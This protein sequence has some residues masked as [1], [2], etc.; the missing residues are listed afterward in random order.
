MKDTDVLELV[1][2]DE[3]TLLSKALI[4]QNALDTI[5]LLSDLYYLP[6]KAFEDETISNEE[7]GMAIDLFRDECKIC[8]EQKEADSNFRKIW[9]ESMVNSAHFVTGK[10]SPEEILLLKDLTA[11]EGELVFNNF[12][13]QM[14]IGYR[15]AFYRF[16]TY[17]LISP[18]L[19]PNQAKFTLQK[20]LM[21]QVLR[22]YKYPGTLYDFLNI[23]GDQ[24]KLSEFCMHSNFSKK[25][26]IGA[27]FF[28][29]V[30]NSK[31]KRFNKLTGKRLRFTKRKDF[32]SG[33][34]NIALRKALDGILRQKPKKQIDNYIKS[35]E[36]KFMLRVL[37]VKLWVLGLYQGKLDHDFG[38]LSLTALKEFLE[39][40]FE[41]NKQN[42]DELKNILYIIK[43]DQCILNFQYLLEKYIIPIEDQE[44]EHKAYEEYYQI[45][46]GKHLE[47]ESTKI[48]KEAK[49]L[50]ENFKSSLID[51]SKKLI[52]TKKPARIY[53]G[54]RGFNKFVSKITK[55][56]KNIASKLLRLIK[57]LIKLLA[58][59]IKQIF[60]EIKEAILTFRQGMSFLF[61]R[62]KIIS[63]HQII[64]D[65]DFDF[66]GHSLLLSN[67]SEDFFQDHLKELRIRSN[68]LYPSIRFATEVIKWGLRFAT[69][70][71]W[72]KI[73]LKMAQILR[74]H[75]I[76]SAKDELVKLNFKI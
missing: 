65:Y 24:F 60:E 36:N 11:L 37:Q 70:L 76:R 55:W 52:A 69:G 13:S 49:I 26:F 50:D 25:G 14:G 48:R 59:T 1:P 34:Q 8:L 42:Q 3:R 5:Q 16:R 35:Q 44:I 43:N 51:H 10:L 19:K 20:D 46:E 6:R 58:K 38:P 45:L 41:Q 40:L 15:I 2:K 75:M 64:T 17:S 66:D 18:Q 57:S 68:A 39:M 23:L 21:E 71:V 31:A 72:P 56:I 73:F 62:R 67:K 33:I 27:T 74:N 28:F 32:L 61:G 47:H 53:K 30:K 9:Q 54:K 22:K 29:E 63:H 7:L 4:K 12:P